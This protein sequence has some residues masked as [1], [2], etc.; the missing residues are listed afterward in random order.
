MANSTGY[1]KK[2][3]SRTH[4]RHLWWKKIKNRQFQRRQATALPWFNLRKKE[5]NQKQMLARKWFKVI[6]DLSTRLAEWS[7]DW[8]SSP[9]RL[10]T[11]RTSRES[12]RASRSIRLTQATRKFAARHQANETLLQTLLPKVETTARRSQ[13]TILEWLSS[14]MRKSEN[15]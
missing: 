4:F 8:T 2:K 7:R 10:S 15:I 13:H 12:T 14:D 1:L 11:V 6:Q 5:R 9:M 3:V